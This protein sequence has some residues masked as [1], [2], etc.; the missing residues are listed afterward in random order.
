MSTNGNVPPFHENAI[1]QT[2]SD[3]EMLLNFFETP[4]QTDEDVERLSRL[5]NALENGSANVPQA[6]ENAEMVSRLRSSLLDGTL[7]FTEDNNSG[8]SALA[9]AGKYSV[10]SMKFINNEAE[11]DDDDPDLRPVAW[12]I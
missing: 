7:N 1:D 2:L 4:P 3:A 8:L 5:L 12:F 9:G 10:F 6:D 11:T